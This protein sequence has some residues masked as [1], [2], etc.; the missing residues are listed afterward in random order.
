MLVSLLWLPPVWEERIA[1]RLAPA[2]R[3]ALALSCVEAAAAIRRLRHHLPLA[4]AS[5][6]PPICVSR[7]PDRFRKPTRARSDALE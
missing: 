4:F 3:A 6:S 1:V 7:A 5:G 2:D